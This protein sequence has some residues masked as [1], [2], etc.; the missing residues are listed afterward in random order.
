MDKA[1][2]LARLTALLPPNGS[3]SALDWIAQTPQGFYD[4]SPG[5]AR[6]IRW[7]LGNQTFPAAKFE[8]TLKRPDLLRQIL[9]GK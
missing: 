9:A 6:W 7:R 2:V 3:L 5:A 4:A 1:Q 8:R